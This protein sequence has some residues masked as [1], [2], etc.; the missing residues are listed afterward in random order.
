[1]FHFHFDYLYDGC[2]ILEGLELSCVR[3]FVDLTN[4]ECIVWQPD[5]GTSRPCNIQEPSPEEIE[6]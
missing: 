5:R 3:Y 4:I 2:L 6:Q 1:M